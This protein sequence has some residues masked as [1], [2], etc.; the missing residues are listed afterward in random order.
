MR[1]M[2]LAAL[3]AAIALGAALQGGAAP[4]SPVVNG[5][6][7]I[8]A[9]APVRDAVCA[10]AGDTSVNVLPPD[11]NPHVPDPTTPGAE[12]PWPWLVSI[13]PCEQ[14]VMKALHWSSSRVTQFA[15]YDGDGDREA[16]IDGSRP[17]DPLIG[18]SHNFWQAYPS[19][20]QAF[21]ADFDALR[22][23][24]E[25]G[26]VPP[27]ALV[28]ISLSSVPFSDVSPFVG[29]FIDC[30]LTFTNLSPTGGVVSRDPVTATFSAAWSGCSDE[31]GAWAAADD[32]GRRA[33]LATMRIVQHSFWQFQTGAPVVLDG[34]DLEGA[35]T[36]AGI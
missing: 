34:V 7:E 6:F 24:V 18:A 25:S 9:P 3:V 11:Q 15:D 28:Q 5:E 31:A 14:G 33:I 22:F 32:A 27:G 17:V 26:T 20:H 23:R 36:I 19:P 13:A 8:A 21:T 10:V 4:V 35:K 12:L 29:L 16:Q 30:F 2:G 1:R